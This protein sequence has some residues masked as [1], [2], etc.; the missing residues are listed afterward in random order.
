MFN[1]GMWRMLLL[2][3][4]ITSSARAGTTTVSTT[5]ELTTALST[6]N[7]GDTIVLNNGNYAGFTVTRSGLPGAPITIQA[8]NLGG[9]TINS[10]SIRL[11]SCWYVTVSGMRFTTSGGSATI[12]SDI[13]KYAIW[14]DSA[15]YCEVT[16]CTLALVGQPS[17]M[18]WI[19]LAGN[20]NNNRISYCEF[21]PNTIGGS[22]HYIFPCGNRD[23]AGVT[24]P[25]DR[26]PWANGLGPVN[27]NMARHTL[28]DHNYFR[29]VDAA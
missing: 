14:F 3:L 26:G 8:A 1:T 9:V 11:Q 24:P 4:L 23:I 21:G 20:S 16:R 10:G 7:P 28:M 17:G 13:R 27:P 6:V 25:A 22:S 12:G 2:S 5:A 19:F 18:N 15:N 29:D